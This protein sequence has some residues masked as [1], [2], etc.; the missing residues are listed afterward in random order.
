MDQQTEISTTEFFLIKHRFYSTVIADILKAIQG[1]SYGGAFVLTFCCIDY[2]SFAMQPNK[3]KNTSG[4]FKAFIRKYL[5]P[6]NEKY[7]EYES[8]LYAFR[9]SL[10]HTYG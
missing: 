3:E 10:V 6:I 4:D 2:M 5:V 9:C 8:Q 7:L 1:G